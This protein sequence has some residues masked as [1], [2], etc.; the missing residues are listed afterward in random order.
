[1]ICFG[2]GFGGGIVTSGLKVEEVEER[3]SRY[4]FVLSEMV[5]LAVEVSIG[6]MLLEESG[7]LSRIRDW[8]SLVASS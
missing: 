4:D 3:T 2:R 1:M 7:I 8:I 6:I 5:L